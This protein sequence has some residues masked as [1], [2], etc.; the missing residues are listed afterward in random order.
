MKKRILTIAFALLLVTGILHNLQPYAIASESPS[1]WAIDGVSNAIAENLVPASLQSN[2]SQATTRAEF[3]ALAVTLYETVT[4]RVITER[5][6]FND[7]NDVNVEKMAAVGVVNGTSPGMFTPGGQLTREQAAAMLSRLAGVLGIPL[8]T[9]LLAFADKASV[10]SW[11]TVA[12]GQMQATGIMGGVGNNM[13]SPK[14]SY[15]RE[16]SIITILRLYEFI[17]ES[18]IDPSALY[19]NKY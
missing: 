17:T 4:G 8:K 12:V 1:S 18:G 7:T 19:N 2:Y 10:S 6:S 14:A 5:S 15:T 13:F 11:A 9:G 16:Q 3:C